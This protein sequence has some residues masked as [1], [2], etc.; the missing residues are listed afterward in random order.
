MSRSWKIRFQQ[1]PPHPRVVLLRSH[2]NNEA[3]EWDRRY[4]NHL[5]LLLQTC[6]WESGPEA[7]TLKDESAGLLVKALLLVWRCLVLDGA[8]RRSP[9]RTVL[10]VGI[11]H[12]P[13][14][15]TGCRTCLHQVVKVFHDP[16]S[17][18]KFQR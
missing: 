6:E 3:H 10:L 16:A 15:R 14:S 13:T 7:T 17:Q 11:A 5:L 4:C 12:C 8:N 1:P 18:H 9:F 2:W